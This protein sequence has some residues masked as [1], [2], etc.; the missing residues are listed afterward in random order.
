MVLPL[1]VTTP[2][3]PAE[4][5][6]VET[7][8]TAPA[9]AR[10]GSAEHTV[11][12]GETATAIA[13]R[14]RVDVGRL[15]ERNNLSS[16]AYIH[17]GQQLRI[18]PRESH[19]GT[20][21]QASRSTP[22]RSGPTRSYTVRTGDTLTGIAARHDMGV[23]RLRSLNGLGQEPI[24][25]GQKLRVHGTAHRP[26]KRATHRSPATDTHTVRAGETLTGIAARHGMSP[27]RLAKTNSLTPGTVIRPGQELKVAR[28]RPAEYDHNTFAGRDYSDETVAA[29]DENRRTLAARDTPSRQEVKDTIV[30]TAKRHGVDPS[31]ALAIAYQ[32]SGWDHRQVS[33]ANAVGT[34]QLIPSSGRWASSMT[35]RDLDLLDAEE[36]ITAG[37]VLIKSLTEQASNTSEAIAGYYQGL[38]SV[39]RGGMYDD[40]KE[41]VSK[42]KALRHQM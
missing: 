11:R 10:N 17:P 30:R 32:E 31:L 7:T 38:A 16:S 28:D 14:Y 41:Y 8:V 20:H 34:M 22:A 9:T 3:T 4:A 40:T 12:V 15:L 24:R 25:T 29:A 18:P 5:P 23:D 33:V 19:A 2:A 39:Q 6:T 35:G 13:T 21:A 36:N 1:L 26:A 42:V 37:V 27:T